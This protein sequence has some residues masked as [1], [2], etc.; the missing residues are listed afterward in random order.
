MKYCVIGN[1]GHPKG[2]EELVMGNGYVWAPAD[3]NRVDMKEIRRVLDSEWIGDVAIWGGD[4][5]SI[6]AIRRGG[7]W[8]LFEGP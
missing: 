6:Q 4:D 3:W 8:I 2:P 5:D 1:A 7:T